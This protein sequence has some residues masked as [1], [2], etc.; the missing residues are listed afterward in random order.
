MAQLC[1][2]FCI[3]SQKIRPKLFKAKEQQSFH[4]SV[5]LFVLQIYHSSAPTL[6]RYNFKQLE[7]PFFSEGK[8]NLLAI[9]II[10]VCDEKCY[11]FIFRGIR[12]TVSKNE[13]FSSYLRKHLLIHN[14]SC[15]DKNKIRSS[16]DLRRTRY[17]PQKV[18]E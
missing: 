13:N 12:T 17:L 3:V 10:Q 18:C 8:I 4:N 11:S 5:T 14:F 7:K 2:T 15:C 9:Y 6:K 1:Y 16:V